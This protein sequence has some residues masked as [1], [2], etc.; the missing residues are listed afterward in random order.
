MT[1]LLQTTNRKWYMAYRMAEFTMT[2]SDRQGHSPVASFLKWDFSYTCAP[3]DKT[4]IDT[5]HR[6]VFLR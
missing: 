5:A 6:A 3:V 1:L 2:L 4:T